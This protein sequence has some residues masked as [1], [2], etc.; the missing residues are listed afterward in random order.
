MNKRTGYQTSL[1]GLVGAMILCLLF[2]AGY[3]GFRAL[4]RD[5]LEV[6]PDSL[7][8]LSLVRA[9][10]EADVEVLYPA[11]LPEGWKVTGFDNKPGE[12]QNLRVSLHT[13]V[14]GRDKF[15]GYTWVDADPDNVVAEFLPKSPRE[16]DEVSIEN[17]EIDSVWHV[18]TSEIDSGLLTEWRGR[19]LLVWGSV[20]QQT[21][22]TLIGTLT[23]ARLPQS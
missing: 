3:V 6:R 19:T 12:R 13:T 20:P 9:L 15:V 17:P 23:T 2:I 5:D 18:W 14:E 4:N 8:Y 1:A 21:M 10:Q 22:E 11:E 16:G 7:D